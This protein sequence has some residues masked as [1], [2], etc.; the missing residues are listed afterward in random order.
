MANDASITASGGCLCGGV[1]YEVRGPMRPVIACH[2]GQCRR[3]HGHYAAYANCARA[4]LTM[5]E[6][7]SLSWFRSSDK[8]RRGFCREC[9]GSVFWAPEGRSYVSIAAGTLDEPTGLATAGHIYV[10]SKGD[11][12]E[13]TDGLEQEP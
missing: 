2:C 13:I 4:D 12:Y 9:G 7:R 3:T 5:V 8:A 1:R 10:A 6:D 11:Y